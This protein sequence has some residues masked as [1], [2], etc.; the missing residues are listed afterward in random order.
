MHRQFLK[1]RGKRRVVDRRGS[2]VVQF[3]ILLPVLTLLLVGVIDWGLILFMDQHL[4]QATTLGTRIR[5]AEGPNY[6]SSRAEGATRAYLVKIYPSLASDFTVTSSGGGNRAWVQ[7][8]IPLADASLTHGVLVLPGG[9]L[10]TRIEMEYL[11]ATP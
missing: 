10:S 6:S 11:T 2:T 4:I 9:N 7:V 3:A 1:R 8:E 5:A